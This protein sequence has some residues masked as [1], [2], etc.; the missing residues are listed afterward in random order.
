M[1]TCNNSRRR[2]GV[3]CSFGFVLMHC[4]SAETLL[5]TLLSTLRASPTMRLEKL[6]LGCLLQ[7]ATLRLTFSL[8]QFLPDAAVRNI[9]ITSSQE[10]YGVYP[11]PQ[12]HEEVPSAVQR[13]IRATTYLPWH[14]ATSISIFTT[15][16]PPS[17]APLFRANCQLPTPCFGVC[18]AF[19]SATSRELQR[20][21]RAHEGSHMR[22]TLRKPAIS[23][24]TMP[25]S[26][27]NV[28]G[29]I[30]YFGRRAGCS[31]YSFPL[32]SSI[33]LCMLFSGVFSLS[34]LSLH[35]QTQ[36]GR[37]TGSATCVFHQVW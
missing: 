11:S 5:I 9:Q 4:D 12:G 36:D 18:P 27:G 34:N 22:A 30:H 32:P 33:V 24:I 31:S 21:N 26:D 37:S 23:V 7:C 28:I 17:V 35:G 6:S 14:T 10:T 13:V 1:S 19:V 2:K 29:E 15:P 8:S 25:C 20:E 3:N 16:P